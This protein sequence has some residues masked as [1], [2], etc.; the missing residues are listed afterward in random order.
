MHHLTPQEFVATQD[1]FGESGTPEQLMDK[2]G[3]N[4]NCDSKGNG[5]KIGMGL[6]KKFSWGIVGLVNIVHQFCPDLL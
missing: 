3:L 2:F 5:Q 6:T 1:T 4:A